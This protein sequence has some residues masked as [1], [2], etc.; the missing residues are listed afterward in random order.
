MCCFHLT[1]VKLCYNG[2]FERFNPCTSD[3]SFFGYVYGFSLVNEHYAILFFW[4]IVDHNSCMVPIQDSILK[5]IF[6]S[7]LFLD[8]RAIVYTV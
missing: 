6:I 3:N 7:K 8:S 1:F 4:V 5:Y 2:Q